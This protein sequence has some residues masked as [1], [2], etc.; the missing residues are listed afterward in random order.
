MSIHFVEA[1]YQNM[2]D[3]TAG[4]RQSCL[5]DNGDHLLVFTTPEKTTY[6]LGDADGSALQC[7]STP[8][9]QYNGSPTVCARPGSGFYAV[10]FAG[11]TSVDVDQFDGTDSLRITFGV[12][13][14][15]A[16]MAMVLSRTVSYIHVVE[17]MAW[18]PGN[19][20]IAADS[21][22]AYV[23]YN[24]HGGFYSTTRVF[25][26]DPTGVLLWFKQFR[27]P[28]GG[29]GP[30][31]IITAPAGD[32]GL[33]FA[34]ENYVTSGSNI[35]TGRLSSIGELLWMNDVVYQSD[36]SVVTLRD[37]TIGPDG[38]AIVVGQLQGLSFR[39]GYVISAAAHGNSTSAHFYD[40]A[41]TYPEF[42]SVRTLEDGSTLLLTSTPYDVPQRVRLL[43]TGPDMEVIGSALSD[44]VSD[45]TFGYCLHPDVLEYQ[46][47]R[48]LVLGSLRSE[49]LIFGT[50]THR[51]T[52]WSLDMTTLDGCLLSDTTVS[53]YAIPDNLLVVTAVLPEEEISITP[54]IL[55]GS[56]VTT[57]EALITVSDM[58]QS[59]VSVQEN[60]VQP[61]ELL[62]FPNPV[63]RGAPISLQYP[64]ASRFV[65]YNTVGSMIR[66]VPVNRGLNI[67]NL[68]CAGLSVGLYQV[69]AFNS[70]YQRLGAAKMEI[71]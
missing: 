50:T 28:F 58:C 64:G 7:F 61:T 9:Y 18:G 5:L 35:L 55:D 6:W 13:G 71:H 69:V 37:L 57:T 43:R 23:L 26:L 41:I 67:T 27:A 33:I 24:E 42:C 59:L 8:V 49:D 40:L 31:A 25:K 21:S 38:Q 53:H 36:F 63:L 39:Y 30:L 44:T 66:E 17:P 32:G 48:A 68:D 56:L 15:D 52:I 45:G 4:Q 20:T 70:R 29:Q 34:R 2:L 10:S 60:A 65:I 22:G 62:A 51:P 12:Q 46:N 1:Q 3:T 19:L 47:G 14:F 54:E 11:S 16:S